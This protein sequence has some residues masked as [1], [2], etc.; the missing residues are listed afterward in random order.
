[1]ITARPA[2]S[3]TRTRHQAGPLRL[4]WLAALL[5]AFL[6]THA[7]GADSASAH[8]SGGAVTVP[9]LAPADTGGAL[10]HDAQQHDRRDDAGGGGGHSHP[11]EACASGHPQQ[12]CDLPHPTAIA[13]RTPFSAATAPQPWTQLPPCGLPPLHSSLSSVVQQ[14]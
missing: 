2:L 3:T 13:V 5:F 14:V 11:A 6:Y 1:M 10:D 8:V 7:A 9:H 4:L 12:S